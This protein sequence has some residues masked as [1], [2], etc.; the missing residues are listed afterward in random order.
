MTKRLETLFSLVEPCRVFAD[1]GCDH[2][3]IS[4]EVL[5]RGVAEKVYAADISAPSL[6]KAIALMGDGFDGRFF[7]FVSDGF[8]KLPDDIDCALIAGLGGEETVHILSTERKLPDTLVL[9]PMKNADKVRKKVVGLGYGIDKDFTF[10]A[11]DKYYDVIRAKK[12]CGYR[13]YTEDEYVFGRDNLVLRS[14]DFLRYA[15][16]RLKVINGAIENVSDKAAELALKKEAAKLME[17]L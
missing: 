2:G 14:E 16:F 13:D 15:A 11:A 1:I 5:S 4:Q 3:I 10:F 8:E 17:L 9:Q 7:A 12:A 6:K